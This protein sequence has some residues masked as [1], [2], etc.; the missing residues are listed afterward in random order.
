MALWPLAAIVRRPTSPPRLIVEAFSTTL[1]VIGLVWLGWIALWVL[2]QRWCVSVRRQRDPEPQ[3]CPVVRAQVDVIGQAQGDHR[4]I[5]SLL[6]EQ[7]LNVIGV[8]QLKR[9]PVLS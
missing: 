1:A 6:L 7:P 2:E 4:L 8:L 5:G 3:P 9:Q